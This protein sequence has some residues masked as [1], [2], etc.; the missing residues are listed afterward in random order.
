MVSATD[1]DY[2]P[3][4]FFRGHAQEFVK[5]AANF[6]GTGFLK[7]FKFDKNICP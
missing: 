5:R 4:S 1:R 6:K 7:E 2:S 3:F